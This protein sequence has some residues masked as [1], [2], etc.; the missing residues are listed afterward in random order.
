VVR[1]RHP[2]GGLGPLCLDVV[3]EV[4]VGVVGWTVEGA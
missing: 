1:R 2:G 3:V 4:V